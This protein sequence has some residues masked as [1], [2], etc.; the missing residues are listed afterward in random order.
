MTIDEFAAQYE[1]GDGQDTTGDINKDGATNAHDLTN[2]MKYV[3]G[4]YKESNVDRKRADLNFDG[5]IDIL[6]IIRLIRYLAGENV[7]LY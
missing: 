4:E 5:A 1:P 6:D 2:L 3:A 7:Q